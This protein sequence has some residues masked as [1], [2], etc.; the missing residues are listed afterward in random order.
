MSDVL[1]KSRASLRF[2]WRIH[3]LWNALIST[4]SHFDWIHNGMHMIW[5][6][7]IV[8]C[9]IICMYSWE[10]CMYLHIM[11]STLGGNLNMN[12]CRCLLLPLM[13]MMTMLALAKAGWDEACVSVRSRKNSFSFK[14]SAVPVTLHEYPLGMM[15]MIISSSFSVLP[16]HQPEAKKKREKP[17]RL[18][19]ISSILNKILLLP[20]GRK[21]WDRFFSF[22]FR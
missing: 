11:S 1:L 20:V 7:Y 2:C 10:I 18:V 17:T 12:V 16:P 3:I 13:M 15:I 14:Y 22:P 5:I 6:G 8:I 21:E 19:F 4:S 9:D